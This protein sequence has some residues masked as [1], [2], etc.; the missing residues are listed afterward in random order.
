MNAYSRLT[1]FSLT[2]SLFISLGDDPEYN[3]SNE[4]YQSV[5]ESTEDENEA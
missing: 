5:F 2:T 3:N 4:D 1:L